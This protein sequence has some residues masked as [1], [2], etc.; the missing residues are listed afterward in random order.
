MVDFITGIESACY[1]VGAG[2]DQSA[3]LRFDCV[4]ILKNAKPPSSNISKEERSALRDL[5]ADDSVLIVPSDKGRATVLLNKT[6]YQEKAKDLLSDSKTY[7]PLPKDPTPKYKSQLIS[8]LQSLCDQD[9]I[10]QATYR[11][12]YPTTCDIPKLYGL[13]KVHKDACPL[14]P[15]LACRGSLMYNTAKFVADIISPLIGCTERHLNNSQD[16]V[17]KL[18]RVILQPDECLVSYDVICILYFDV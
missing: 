12:L 10:S 16:L 3:R 6:A 8:L 11:H 2:E 18:S 4:D 1:R 5:K 15:I 13:P 14:R 17:Q 9:A 7:Q